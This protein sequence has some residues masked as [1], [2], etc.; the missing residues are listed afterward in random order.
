ML[1]GL[2]PKPVL[3]SLSQD[4]NDRNLIEWDV[5]CCHGEDNDMDCTYY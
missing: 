2:I 1:D 5:E 4:A 3:V